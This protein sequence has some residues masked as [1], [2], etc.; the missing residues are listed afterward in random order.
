MTRNRMIKADFWADEKI[1][2][3]PIITRLLFIG[4]WNFADDGGICRAN[5]IYLR[6]NIF[7]YDDISIEEIK[8]AIQQLC[9][10]GVVA[11]LEYSGERYLQ[12]KN[13]LKHQT[14]NKP[15]KFRYINESEAIFSNS[16]VVV[17]EL[18]PLKEKEKVKV[19]KKEN[20]KI[21]SCKQ[22]SIDILNYFNSIAGKGFKS[23]ESNL[24]LIKG[25]L[26]EYSVN[27]LKAM[28]DFK[29][30]EWG[31]DKNMSKYLRPETLFNATKCASYIEQSKV[32]KNTSNQEQE[33]EYERL[34]ADYGQ[35]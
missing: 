8:K 25:R 18:S 23:I 4:T 5:E 22:D 24:K 11:L 27:E 32:T 7:P 26:N 29:V 33:D 17:E 20:E 21:T 16:V 3:M 31:N 19:N 34:S 28:I 6:N 15:S 2:N 12:I 13:F 35:H 9:S 14:I 10:S 1:G 30:S